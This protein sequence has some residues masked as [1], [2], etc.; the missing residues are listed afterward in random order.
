MQSA[1]SPG[2][3]ASETRGS[4]R[5]DARVVAG[6]IAERIDAVIALWERLGEDG[7]TAGDPRVGEP[8]DARERFLR[9]LALLLVAGLQ[10]SAVHRALYLDERLRYLPKGVAGAERAERFRERLAREG[11]A[12]AE[13]LAGAVEP[14][15]VRAELAAVN[16]PLTQTPADED[17][18]VLLV[19]DCL[20]NDVR[21]FLAQETRDA[22]RTLDADHLYFSAGN[23][24]LATEDI[25]RAIAQT[26]PQVIGLSL[27]TYEGIPPYAAL[28]AGAKAMKAD[29][30]QGQ[31]AAL[32]GM[33][34][35]SI[36]AIR[37][38][39]DAP[40]LVHTACALPVGPRRLKYPFMPVQTRARRA[41]VE[42]ITAEVQHLVAATENTMLVDEARL[43][44][45]AGGVRRVGRAVLG[46]EYEGAYLHPSYFGPVLAAEYADV[47]RSYEVLGSAKALLVD[48]DNTLWSGVMADGDVVHDAEGQRL[49]RR[50]KDAGVLL[51]ALSK[52][53]PESI[54]WDE[55]ELEPDDFVLH[56]VDWRPKPEGV[57]EAIATL[58]L[59]PDAFVLLD[60]N[61]VER[62]LVQ[63]NVP[64]VRALDPT[65]PF[66]W[67]S[68]RRWLEFPSTKQTEEARRR[69]ELYREAAER[70]QAMGTEHDYASMMRSLEL[71]AEVR[72]ATADDL[73]RLLELIQ[74]T[75]QF[76]TTTR[77]RSAAEVSALLGSAA[78]RVYVGS[79]R[80]RFGDLGVVAVA[81]VD[82]SD[83]GH[84][85]IDS[86][87][88]SC[89]AMGF[90]LE[91]LMLH[92]VVSAEAAPAVRGPFVPTERN[93][94]A[95]GLY[96][97]NGFHEEAPG[98]WVLEDGAA[99]PQRPDWFQD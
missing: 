82:R 88:M 6:A 56:K 1:P 58:D 20:F 54:R 97:A 57:S 39:T 69:T 22:G 19:G 35:S 68:L 3:A 50:L 2:P 66:T 34:R 44:E 37:T 84:A 5:A 77:R 74:R 31:I 46:P 89:R 93:G 4:D 38:A 11:E 87:I 53:D 71:R 63:E 41:V 25:T 72:D 75:N 51:V 48:F 61:P 28:L 29:E 23:Q 18:R 13:L 33:L 86:F 62:A 45:D 43:I 92:D 30:L 67:R 7:P 94:P 52:N 47:I 16:A 90:G 59:A 76:N 32:V 96:A 80:D 17:V 21:V 49:L 79:L 81:V 15:T 73:P 55:L 64:G 10:G 99:G 78:H 65:D 24:P 14:A 95:A 91:Q 36:E 70:R 9:P 83:P 12:I 42:R 27:F 60:D 8:E 40:I 26:P 85:E 98:T